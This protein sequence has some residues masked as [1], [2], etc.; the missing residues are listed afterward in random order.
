MGNKK[1]RV[2]NTETDNLVS[3]LRGEIAEIVTTWVL[4][5]HFMASAAGL[6][7]DDV[8]KDFANPDLSFLYVLKDKLEDELVGRLS[9][10]AEEKIGRLNFYFAA[11]KLGKFHSE[12][13]DFSRYVEKKGFRQK[14]NQD[15][16]HKELPE[17]WEDHRAPLHIPYRIILRAIASAI[18]VMK[19]IDRQV[20]GPS[21][22]YL[23]RETRKR[24]YKPILSPPRVAYMMVPH[25]HLSGEDRIQIIQEEAREGTV[26]WSEMPTTI[27]GVPTKVLASIKWGVLKFGDRFLA[28]EAYPLLDLAGIQVPPENL[29]YEDHM[30]HT[31]YRCTHS[32]AAK[33]SFEPVERTHQFPDG[34]TTELADFTIN[35]GDEISKNLGAVQQGD[36]KEFSL[37]V[38]ALKGF[39]MTAGA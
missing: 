27:N 8:K 28:L 17:K 5:R 12:A 32:S 26:V 34:S 1:L 37:N 33:L 25:F 24:R 38:R 19:R 39:E 3:N 9:E 35:L 15:I 2:I 6:Q 29:I 14:R 20:L 11:E 23:W 7:T 21:S 22:P 18:R 31:Q 13:A 16:S 30:I 4:M 36:I 10:L